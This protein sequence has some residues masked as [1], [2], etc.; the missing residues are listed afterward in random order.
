V[1]RRRERSDLTLVA[2]CE[3]EGLKPASYH[4]WRRKIGRR[5]RER[6]G[7][8]AKSR[9]RS[10]A[11]GGPTLAR[12]RVIDDRPSAVVEIVVPSGLV[13][14]VPE[15]VAIEHLRRVLELVRELAEAA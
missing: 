10:T 1:L 14:R 12:V 13:V 8:A 2:F 3:Q 6:P 11:P 4:Y 7:A 15:G 5:D 9:R